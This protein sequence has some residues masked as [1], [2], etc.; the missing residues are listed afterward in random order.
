MLD[1]IGLLVD[2]QSAAH[3]RLGLRQT[4]R[5]LEQLSQVVETN[6]DVGVLGT[7]GLLVDRQHATHQRLGFVPETFCIKQQTEIVHE[8]SC[9]RC[10]NPLLVRVLEERGSMRANWVPARPRA[11][12]TR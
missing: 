5:R 2:R 10:H 12:V 9:C 11:N 4:V 1:T 3:Q 7:V 6:S 8:S